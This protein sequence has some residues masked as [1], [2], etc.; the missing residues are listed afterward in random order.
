MG[1]SACVLAILEE[2]YKL[3]FIK[4]PAPLV[5]KN[6]SSV[7]TH[8]SFVD[9]A[10]HELVAAGAAK[11]AVAGE[12][13]MVSLLGVVDGKKLRLILDLRVLKKSLAKFRLRS[14]CDGLRQDPTLEAILVIFGR[15]ALIFF[16]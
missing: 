15:R 16:R 2:G 7:D 4:L 11:R 13:V 10:F 5:M 1:A 14:R 9:K 6:H 8:S 3:P 12:V